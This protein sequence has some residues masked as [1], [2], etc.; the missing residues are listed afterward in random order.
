MSAAPADCGWVQTAASPAQIA[1]VFRGRIGTF[2]SAV[3]QTGV[4][5]PETI[6]AVG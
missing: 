6:N 4:N 5:I 3:A 1:S 2:P